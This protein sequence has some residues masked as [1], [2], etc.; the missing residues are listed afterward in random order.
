MSDRSLTDYEMRIIAN[1]GNHGCHVVSVF[2]PQDDAQSFAYSVGFWE[3]VG[4][5]EVIILGL[6]SQMGAFAINEAYR[7]CEAGLQLVDGL[8]IESLFEGYAVTCM[9]RAV[10]SQ[11]IIPDYL[12]SALW[13]HNLR[14]GKSL[15]VAYQLVWT[16]EGLWPWDEGAPV[17]L[18]E[19]QPLLYSGILH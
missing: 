15:D 16:Y 4:Q 17:E 7:Q 13:Y 1:I 19:D 11:Y 9:A 14:T 10:D 18:L 2:D 6:P 3:S 8:R 5:P 12:N